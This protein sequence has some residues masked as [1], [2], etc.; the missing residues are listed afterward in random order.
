MTRVLF[1]DEAELELSEAV[2]H[3]EN[4]YSGLGLDFEREVKENVCRI[5]E[6]PELWPLRDDETRRFSTK[7]FPY[8]IVYSIHEDA[9][10]IVA[11]AHHKRFPGYWKDRL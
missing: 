6:T 2:A 9:I 8:Q 5:S 3:Y 4:I 11:V 7:R 1:L 10:W